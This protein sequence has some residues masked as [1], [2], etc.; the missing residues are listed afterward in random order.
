[1]MTNEESKVYD[2]N[3]KALKKNFKQTIGKLLLDER[4]KRNQRLEDISCQ[5]QIKQFRIEDIEFGKHKFHWCIVAKL[6]EIY[7]KRLEIKLIDK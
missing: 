3:G 1:M 2:M 7:N 4:I 6:L 5:T